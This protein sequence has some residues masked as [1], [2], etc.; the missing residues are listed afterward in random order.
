MVLHSIIALLLG[1][2]TTT[3]S[4]IAFSPPFI[5]D[6][7]SFSRCK[8]NLLKAGNNDNNGNN[9]LTITTT[10]LSPP[11]FPSSVEDQIRLAT[12]SILAAEANGITRHNIRLLLPLIGATELDDWPGGLPQQRDAASPLINDILRQVERKRD[13]SS[14]LNIQESLLPGDNDGVRVVISQ[15]SID[16]KNDA[17]AILL[18]TAEVVDQIQKLDT[19]VGPKRNLLLVNPQY[20]RVSDFGNALQGFFSKRSNNMQ[21]NYVEDTFHPTFVCTSF[22]VEGE[23]IRIFRSYPGPWRVYKLQMGTDSSS[24][25]WNQIGT[26]QVKTI[27]SKSQDSKNEGGLLFAYGQPSYNEIESMIT[28]QDGYVPKSLSERAANAFTFIKDTL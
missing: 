24:I 4:A 13:G 15:S 21:I 5:R 28:S 25:S 14:S 20:R 7:N 22:M 18:P 27:T 8:N 9:S 19:Q 17:C 3:K 2:I 23:Q 11:R 12:D 16:P 1:L 6:L 10:S 26:K